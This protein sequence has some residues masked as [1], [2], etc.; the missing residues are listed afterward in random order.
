VY[1]IFGEV[2]ETYGRFLLFHVDDSE[3]PN[4]NDVEPSFQFLINTGVSV[5]DIR[6]FD[7]LNYLKKF[8]ERLL[9]DEEFI[10]L[11]A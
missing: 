3:P 8:T 6:C 11:L 7:R 2:D 10:S 5:D 9:N 4:W 1:R